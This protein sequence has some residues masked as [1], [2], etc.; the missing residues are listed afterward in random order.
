MRKSVFI[1]FSV[2]LFSH[3]S[4]LAQQSYSLEEC[5]QMA[6][7]QNSQMRIAANKTIIAKQE[8]MEAA[9][10]FLPSLTLS[11]A[12]MRADDGLVRMPMGGQTIKLLDE[13]L[14]GGAM[15]SLPVYAGGQIYN[16]HKLATLG[17]EVSGLQLRQTTNEVTLTVEQYYWN[18]LILK[19]KLL[20]LQ[21][22]KN[23][24]DKINSDVKVAVDAGIRN[25][26]DLL[27]VELRLNETQSAIVNIENNIKVCKMLLAQYIG[28]DWDGFNV[29][30]TGTT[31]LTSPECLYVNHDDHL[32]STVEYQLLSKAVD[33]SKLEMRL[34]KGQYLPTIALGGC[35]LYNDFMGPSQNSFIGMVNVTIPISW[36]APYSVRKYK[37]RHKNAVAE[38]DNGS[39]KLVIR[40]QKAQVDLENAYQQ[41][42]IARNS[43][44]QSEEN[45]RLNEEY[46]K[47]GT[48][49][50]S[51]LLE[52]QQLF[53]QSKDRYAEAYF[54]YEICK[55]EY[56]QSTG[57]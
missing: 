11:G 44:V 23:L 45:L 22:V 1:C 47:A 18:I 16:G 43:I 12:A 2:L 27:Q 25:R 46:Y 41:A 39:Q 55:T 15:A 56:L 52:A 4:I 37:Y 19:E 34:N 28:V 20:T 10:N 51:D 38:L 5:K 9:T 57:R 36:K 31:D 24:L 26:N 29:Q 35:Y 17:L 42:I 21:Q 14:L 54:K 48:S 40:M 49:G 3:T 13:G 30:T 8:K 53:Q 33:A 7:A 50:M 6:L 32:Y